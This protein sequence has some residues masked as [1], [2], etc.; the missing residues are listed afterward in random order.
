MNKVKDKTIT[1]NKRTIGYKTIAYLTTLVT[2]LITSNYLLGWEN[3]ETIPKSL[4]P[5]S[6]II[7]MLNPYLKYIQAVLILVF[8]YLSINVISTLIYLRFIRISDHP[9]AAAVRSIFKISG[10]AVLVSVVASLFNV[11]PAA[12]L[13]VGSFGGLVIGFAT[14]TIL[15]HVVA[16]VFLLLTRPFI[17]GDIITVSGQTGRVKEIKLMHLVLDSEDAGKLILIPSGSVVNQ[18]IQKSK[19]SRRDRPVGTVLSLDPVPS[20][21]VEGSEIVFTGRL[22]EAD[23]GEPVSGAEVEI[24][25]NDLVIDDLLVSGQSGDDGRFRVPWRAECGDWVDRNLEIYA[26]FQGNSEY[27]EARSQEYKIELMK[28]A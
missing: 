10:I 22:V 19:N 14:Q 12:A 26:E 5:Y 9:T 23:T 8:G 1:N 28:Q 25:E 3:L 13:T 21:L 4:Q 16:G 27:R 11:N 17:Y 6:N 15:S 20:S 2:L 18:I 7:L 24:C